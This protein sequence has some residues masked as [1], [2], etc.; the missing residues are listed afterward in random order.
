MTSGIWKGDW[1]SPDKMT[2]MDR[3]QLEQSDIVTFH[4]YDN[5]TEFERRINF[6]KR[7]NRPLICTE[8]MARSVGS[9]FDTILPVAKAHHVAAINWGFVAGKTQT[10]FPW[11]SWQRPY[12]LEKPAVWFHDIFTPDGKPYRDEEVSLIRQMTGVVVPIQARSAAAGT[13]K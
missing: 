6:L 3:L 2:E 5:P 9:T 12:V 13:A 11:D 1:S 8:Y 10:Y 4:N 7:Y